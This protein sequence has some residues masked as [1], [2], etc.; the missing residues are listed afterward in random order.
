MESESQPVVRLEDVHKTF[1]AGFLRRQTPVLR[2]V[3]L[4]I[5]RGEIFALLGRNGAGKTTLMK[6]LLGLVRPTRGG[7]RLLGRPLGDRRAR[8][9][10]GFQ[11]EQPYLYPAL[12]VRE[13]LDLMAGLS[14]MGARQARARVGEVTAVCDLGDHL[15][16]PVRKLSRGWLQRL[17]LA[18]ALL[19]DPR[20][21]LLD[22]PLGGLDPE[23]RLVTKEIIRHLRQGGTTVMIN[24]HILP[25]VEALADRIALL[26]EGRIIATGRLSDLLE[27]TEKRV[28]IGFECPRP[29]E[30]PDGCACVWQWPEMGRYVWEVPPQVVSGL[31][32]DLLR[33][34]A[35]IRSVVPRREGLEAYFARETARATRRAS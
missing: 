27:G 26:E 1:T 14:R 11:P 9:R 12:T 10:I 33:A 15:G 29:V 22:E 28:E 19:P 16:M 13:T 17:T 30:I 4:E 7:G 18:A 2:G 34:G 8:A 5:G 20:F 35:I 32:E 25:D 23:A 6:I 31:L 24:S 21:L 3:E